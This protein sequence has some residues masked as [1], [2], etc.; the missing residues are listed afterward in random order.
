[1][2]SKDKHVQRIVLTGYF[3]LLGLLLLIYCLSSYIPD[4]QLL[5]RGLLQDLS[6]NFAIVL[7]MALGSYFLLRPL[8]QDNERKNLEDF[9]K[10]ALEL[11]TLEKGVR[12][13][14]VVR[15]YENFTDALLR[16][17]LAAAQQRA[18]IFSIWLGNAEER[19]GKVFETLLE[20]GISI[21]I[22]HGSPESD[23]TKL[24][25]DSQQALFPDAESFDPEFLSRIIKKDNAYFQNLKVKN[26]DLEVRQ[27]S[28]MPPFSM[29]LIDDNVFVGFYGYG[30]KASSTPRI[31]FRFDDRDENFRYF[32]NFILNQF[33][34][35]WDQSPSSSET[36]L[37]KMPVTSQIS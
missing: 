13:A 2:I 4:A 15:I 37:G 16:E 31:E 5:W 26:G 3:I 11:L 33:D 28:I 21:R 24:R 1:M 19:W 18:Y 12:E 25:A 36:D 30:A 32:K 10:A 20:K 9:Q 29:I 35:I 8:L 34:T 27:F 22:L 14:G 6:L 23:V 7:A 17:R